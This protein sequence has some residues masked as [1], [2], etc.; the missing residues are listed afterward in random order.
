[1]TGICP[2]CKKAP[3]PIKNEDGTLNWKN[4]FH[5]D[6]LTLI[7]IAMILFSA[8][9]YVHDTETCREI[10][11]NPCKFINVN[12]CIKEDNGDGK[13]AGGFTF[14]FTEAFEG[15]VS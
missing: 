2:H 5:I 13:E 12:N 15:E 11:S 4:L 9:V 3:Y 10:T 7:L 8:W 6:W 1:M 14:N